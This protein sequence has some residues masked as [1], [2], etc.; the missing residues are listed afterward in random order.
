MSHPTSP[1]PA[2]PTVTQAP[3]P[4]AARVQVYLS[5]HRFYSYRDILADLFAG[6]E[7]TF[8]DAWVSHALPPEMEAVIAETAQ[9]RTLE[10]LL[11]RRLVRLQGEIL[12]ALK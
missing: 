5:T 1:P 10:L 9:P 2:P 3:L 12:A 8:L 7:D 4:L 11:L 6:N